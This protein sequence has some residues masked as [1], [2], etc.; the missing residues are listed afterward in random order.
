MG[1]GGCSRTT[2][3]RRGLKPKKIIWL[4]IACEANS[5]MYLYCLVCKS[6]ANIHY[7]HFGQSPVY[8][9]H[10]NNG[11]HVHDTWRGPK[12]PAEPDSTARIHTEKK[13]VQAS[14]SLQPGQGLDGS[15]KH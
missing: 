13:P 10:A 3:E 9:V 12:F 6:Q 8:R 1:I 5:D 7:C 15:F 11:S 4:Y 2:G 14:T